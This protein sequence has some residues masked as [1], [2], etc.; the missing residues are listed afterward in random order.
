M[1]IRCLHI[2]CVLVCKTAG[3]RFSDSGTVPIS[4]FVLLAYTPAVFVLLVV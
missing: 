3:V 4:G 1:I 2:G